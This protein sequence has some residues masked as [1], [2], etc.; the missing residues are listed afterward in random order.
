MSATRRQYWGATTLATVGDQH[1]LQPAARTPCNLATPP[2]AKSSTCMAVYDVS[3]E[4]VTLDY[5]HLITV[6]MLVAISAFGQCKM[7]NLL[8]QY[9]V[10]QY[11][12]KNENTIIQIYQFNL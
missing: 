7:P 5:H 3:E 8:S 2:A 9:S 6:F 10:D 1:L 11:W 12:H 4:P